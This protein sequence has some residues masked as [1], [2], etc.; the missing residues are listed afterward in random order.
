MMKENSILPKLTTEG[1][2]ISYKPRCRGPRCDVRWTGTSP[3]Q[4]LHAHK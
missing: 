1:L 2:E 4:L 3:L